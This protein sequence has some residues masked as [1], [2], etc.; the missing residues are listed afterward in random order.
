MVDSHKKKH[1]TTYHEPHGGGARMQMLCSSCSCLQLD[2]E[3]RKHKQREMRS[4]LQQPA[5][6][7]LVVDDEY[8]Q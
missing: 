7:Q 8:D 3:L 1:F 2:I 4:N 5:A 6:L